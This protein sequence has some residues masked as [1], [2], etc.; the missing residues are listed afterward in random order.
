MKSF[1]RYKDNKGFTLLF[2]VLVAT[3]VLAIGAS[4]ITIGLKQ[5]IFSGAGRESQFSFYAADSGIECALYWDFATSTA[6]V[7]ATSS[8]SSIS[9]G[10]FVC[11]SGDIKDGTNFEDG[12]GEFVGQL[13]GSNFVVNTDT[14]SATT[15]FRMVIDDGDNKRCVQVQVA[16][17]YDGNRVR[18]TID[19]RGYNSC[20]ADFERRYE[21][22]LRTEY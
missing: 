18:T 4:I 20:D 7:F 21:R 2:A 17:W 6:R 16:K 11:G 10:P 13:N 3:L 1:S 15:T 8:S 19:S 14:D 9:Q 22:G 12:T 5:I